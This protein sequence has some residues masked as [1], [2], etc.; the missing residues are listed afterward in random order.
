M[1]WDGYRIMTLFHCTFK[2]V[3]KLIATCKDCNAHQ[4]LN[5]LCLTKVNI[6]TANVM[7]TSPV[8]I[9]IY[10]IYSLD[11]KSEN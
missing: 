5:P 9:Y 10:Y 11:K 2:N 6:F 1:Y 3:S 7:C 8:Y 4:G